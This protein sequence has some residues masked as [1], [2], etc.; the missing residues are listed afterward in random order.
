VQS[1]AACV[2]VGSIKRRAERVNYHAI[3]SS[4]FLHVA[5]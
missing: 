5:A 3:A 1:A 2:R 4:F